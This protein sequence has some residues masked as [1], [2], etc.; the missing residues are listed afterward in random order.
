MKIRES[1]SSGREWM[2]AMVWWLGVTCTSIGAVAVAAGAGDAGGVG[3]ETTN[4]LGANF[5]C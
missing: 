5:F 1:S 3:V 4:A 2:V